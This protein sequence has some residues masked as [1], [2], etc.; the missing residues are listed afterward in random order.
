MIFADPAGGL[1]EFR[2]VLRPGRCAAVCVMSTAGRV[3]MWGALAGALSA[4]LPQDRDLLHLSFAPVDHARLASNFRTAGSA[5]CRSGPSN[6]TGSSSHSTT[7]E[8]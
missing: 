6:E 2:R 4:A 1:R 5:M 3:P 8:G 7:T